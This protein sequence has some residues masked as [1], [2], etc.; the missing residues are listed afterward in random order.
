[1]VE[2]LYRA[3]VLHAQLEYAFVQLST[4]L[5]SGLINHILS[6]LVVNN[7]IGNHVAL[8]VVFSR[9]IHFH[10]FDKWAPLRRLQFPI[11]YFP[12]LS[13]L[14]VCI[15]IITIIIRLIRSKTTQFY[16]SLKYDPIPSSLQV[17]IVIIVIIIIRWIRFETT[18]F[19][20]SFKELNLIGP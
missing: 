12:V 9:S 17:C 3:G 6:K 11:R 1:M 5:A 2:G 7:D 14:H 15:V 20:Q 10:V 19:Y 4:T 8:C 18:Q 13:N 16:Q